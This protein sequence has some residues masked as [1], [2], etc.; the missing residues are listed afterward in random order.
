MKWGIMG[1]M[2]SQ[3]TSLTIIYSTVYS[4]ANTKDGRAFTIAGYG[5]Q[6]GGISLPV[7]QHLIGN[8]SVYMDMCACTKAFYQLIISGHT[9]PN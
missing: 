4:G 3:I 5:C 6:D 2:A 1:A 8:E 7:M 9:F